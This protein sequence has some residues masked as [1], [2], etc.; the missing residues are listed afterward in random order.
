M[1]TNLSSLGTEL[2]RSITGLTDTTAGA[3]AAAA[4]A[5]HLA[6]GI[7][8]LAARGFMRDEFLVHRD[9]TAMEVSR[10]CRELAVAAPPARGRPVDLAG[11]LSDAS[12]IVAPSLS[13]HQRWAV[14]SALVDHL[15]TALDATSRLS[16]SG[17]GARMLT[18]LASDRVIAMQQMTSAQPARRADNV[19]LEQPIV[20]P[21]TIDARPRTSSGQKRAVADGIA[22]LAAASQPEKGLWSVDETLAVALACE[23]I[24][25][26]VSRDAD[27]VPRQFWPAHV[28]AADSWRLVVAQLSRLEQPDSPVDRSGRQPLTAIAREVVENLPGCSVG[29]LADVTQ[30][31]PALAS[32]SSVS[33]S[34]WQQELAVFTVEQRSSRLALVRLDTDKLRPLQRTLDDTRSLAVGRADAVG[35]DNPVALRRTWLHHHEAANTFRATDERGEA[36]ARVHAALTRPAAAPG[37]AR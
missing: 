9:R 15:E 28:T 5:G 37:R 24:S 35:R 36:Q 16:T 34:G 8:A 6:R 17:T 12:C 30:Q 18:E 27:R 10:T 2:D 13:G 26:I 11:A 32:F 1:S 7:A 20:D 29:D 31:L 33:V 25:A 19:V 3:A 4:V 21:R 23:H 14:A 22:H